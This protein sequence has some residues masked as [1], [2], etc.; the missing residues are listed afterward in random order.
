MCASNRRKYNLRD[1]ILG[2]LFVV[3][4]CLILGILIQAFLSAYVRIA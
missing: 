2:V 3:T 1:I 4:D